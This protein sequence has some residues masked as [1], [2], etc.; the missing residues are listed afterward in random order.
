MNFY[1]HTHTQVQPVQ[2]VNLCFQGNHLVLD[3]QLASL[4]KTGSLAPSIPPL[5]I[6][7]S[8]FEV[9]VS[10]ASHSLFLLASYCC[11]PCSALFFFQAAMLWNCRDAASDI[12]KRSHNETNSPQ[13]QRVILPAF[14]Q[15]SQSLMC[16]C[17]IIDAFFGLSSTTLHFG[18]FSSIT[19]SCLLQREVPLMR[20]EDDVYLWVLGQRF[21]M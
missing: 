11:C 19:V 15:W 12:L 6:C 1:T 18:W 20:G 14:L 10:W 7:S 21:I 17:C 9:E 13:T 16:F 2:P 3:H 8:S 5:P 4:Q